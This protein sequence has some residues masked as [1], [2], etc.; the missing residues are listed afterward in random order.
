MP[1]I[2]HAAGTGIEKLFDYGAAMVVLVLVL[3]AAA[4]FIHYLLKRCDDRF[5]QSLQRYEV[6]SAKTAEVIDRNTQ[7]YAQ[8]AV[9]MADIKDELKRNRP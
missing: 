7:A 3:L 1:S 2:E 5:D 4:W 9:L 6:S 8:S